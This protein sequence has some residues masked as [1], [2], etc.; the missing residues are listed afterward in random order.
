MYRP[1]TQMEEED[2][3]EDLK[4]S[5][6]TIHFSIIISN[7]HGSEILIGNCGIHNINWK[8]RV[9]EAGIVIGEKQ[10]QNKGYGTETMELLLEYGFTTVN[11]NRI[12]LNVYDYNSRA[13][14]LYKKLGL[15]EE[16][17]RRQSV[18]IKGSYH[19]AI[20]MG[21]LAKEWRD[22]NKSI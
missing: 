18:W 17:R 11:L 7:K 21:M 19:D 12:E 22:M 14:K 2:W 8:N 1:L 4:N 20:M 13:L 16:G 5:K 3:L 6:D 9:G 10:Y 15:T